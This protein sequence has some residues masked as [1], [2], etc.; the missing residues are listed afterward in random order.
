MYIKWVTLYWNM[1]AHFTWR[2]WTFVLIVSWFRPTTR[3]ICGVLLF[4][5]GT[6]IEAGVLQTGLQ[7]GLK[8]ITPTRWE[9]NWLCS[10]PLQMDTQRVKCWQVVYVLQK[11]NCLLSCHS[12]IATKW[13]SATRFWNFYSL[14]EICKVGWVFCQVV[15]PW[16]CTDDKNIMGMSS[17]NESEQVQRAWASMF[18]AC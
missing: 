7:H 11:H 2:S 18:Y 10:Y 14:K 6:Y 13:L 12:K 8:I 3:E 9:L 1:T 5:T 4:A 15:W 16:Y 17:H